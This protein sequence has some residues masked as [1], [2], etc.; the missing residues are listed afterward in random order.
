MPQKNTYAF[1]TSYDDKYIYIQRPDQLLIISQLNNYHYDYPIKT[2]QGFKK[3]IVDEC[4]IFLL[5]KDRLVIDNKNHFISSIPIF[6]ANKYEKDLAI[7]QTFIDSI[8]IMQDTNIISIANKLKLVQSKYRYNTHTEIVKRLSALENSKFDHISYDLPKGYIACYKNENFPLGHR[9]NCMY[10]LIDYYGHKAEYKKVIALDKQRQKYF[11]VSKESDE[12]YFQSVID[13]TRKYLYILDSLD[14]SGLSEDSIEYQKIMA[15]LIIRKTRWFCSEGCGGCDLSPVFSGLKKF[16]NK[17]PQSQLAD[18]A[19]FNLIEMSTW[20][21]PEN[22]EIQA[23]IR[24]YRNFIL[25]YPESDKIADA[26]FEYYISLREFSPQKITE[27]SKAG[28]A[29]IKRHPADPRVEHIREYLKSSAHQ[30]E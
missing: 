10:Y 26:R 16:V 22:E 12:N 20:Y 14:G 19:K 28:R 21:I 15:L 30:E 5:F 17:Y 4:H 3:M 25:K 6:D 27:I 9:K 13:S 11:S 23:S 24:A 7:Y 8:Q 18:N 1:Q 29:F 2:E